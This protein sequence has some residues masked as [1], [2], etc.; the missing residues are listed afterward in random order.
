MAED[1]PGF[2]PDDSLVMTLGQPLIAGGWHE[3][4]ISV[5]EHFGTH[6]DA[7]S[8][9]GA[10]GS[11]TV[12]Q[13]P[14]RSLVG[15][16]AVVDVRE[17]VAADDDYELGV[18]DLLA[19]EARHGTIAPASVVVMFSGWQDRWPDALAYKN[20]RQGVHHFPGFSAD[21]ARWL[22]AN[23]DIRGLGIDTLSADPGRSAELPVHR[24]V[25]G[26]GKWLVENL[27]NLHA[28]PTVGGLMVVAPTKHRGGSGGPARVF[29]FFD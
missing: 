18:A 25:L 10:P 9:L 29:T 5:A 23:R 21:S 2:F 24:I 1:T 3:Y 12:E 14:P 22:L 7:P 6:L 17:R 26:A 19:W 8:H 15:P 28:I 11:L 27:A 4:R 16:V 20:M 13:I